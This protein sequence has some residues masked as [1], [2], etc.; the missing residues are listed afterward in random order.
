MKYEYILV[1][2]ITLLLPIGIKLNISGSILDSKCKR[3]NK[4]FENKSVLNIYVL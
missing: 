3:W 2:I 1:I 4:M